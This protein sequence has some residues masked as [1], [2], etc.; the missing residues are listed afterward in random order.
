MTVL[1]AIKGRYSV[2]KFKNKPVGDAELGKILEAARFSQSAKNLQEW[3]LIVVKN[4]ET[5][6]KLQEAA[7][8]QP[9]VG[10]APVVIAC[11]GKGTG[12]IM[13]CGQPAYSID[14]SIAMENMALEA[15]ELGLGTCWIGAFYEDKVKS[16]LGIPDDDIRVV[17]MLVIGWPDSVA[18]AKN[19]LP[20]ETIVKYEKW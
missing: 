17:G 13:T 7:K 18:P 12:Y 5:R 6:L 3:R 10:D 16:I 9:Q 14:V 1:E 19:R 8:G 4:E 2:R 15:H 11:C 20:M